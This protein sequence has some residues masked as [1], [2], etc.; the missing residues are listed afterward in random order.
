V[1]VV[2]DAPVA[3]HGGASW[4]DAGS[5]ELVRGTVHFGLDPRAVAN[6][7][8]V[9]LD[10]AAV[11]EDGLVPFDAD[12][13]ILRPAGGA[14]ARRLLFVVANRG[15]LGGVP[16]GSRPA[17]WGSS[18][19]DPGDGLVLRRG[20]TVAWCG[21]QWDVLRQRGG[22]GLSAPQA[23]DGGAP[24]AGQLRV[25][26]HSAV[27]LADHALSDSSPLFAFADYPTA[28][29]DDPT[30]VLT[31]RDWQEGPRQ[32]I[33]RARW[34]FAHD[35]EGT[36]VA[37]DT[38]VWLEGGFEP[39][40]FYE[41][42]YRT[43]ICPIA[44]TG[45][46]AMRDFVSFLRHGASGD[47][48]PCAD[49]IDHAV[50]FGVSQSARALRQL[51]YEGMNVD[52]A[53]RRVF[54]GV[55]AHI[56][57]GRRG[58]FNHRYAQPS[59]T[60]TA[61]FGFLPPF[62]TDRADGGGLYARQRRIGGVPRTMFT[63]SSWEY[64]RGGAGL[65]HIDSDIDSD[66]DLTDPDD[67]RSY[68]FAGMDHV[69]DS[70]ELKA[71]LPLANRPNPI[72]PALLLRAAFVNIERWVCDDVAPPPSAV[73][74]L[75]DATAVSRQDVLAAFP[76]VPG[77]GF[78]DP[79]VLPSINHIDLGPDAERGI[80]R[81]PIVEGDPYPMY[82]SSID[83]DGNEVAGVRVPELAVPLGTSTAW[84]P[85]T[86]VDGLPDVIFEFAGSWFPFA[87]AVDERD[88]TG[89]RRPSI[90]ERYD[91]RDDYLARVRAAA[92]QLVTERFLLAEDVDLA[93]ERA[94]RLYDQ[95]VATAT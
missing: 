75:S 57:G 72:G 32:T 14:G 49:T 20:W 22:L 69:G 85:R 31:V 24:I 59:V 89:D 35:D 77:A 21:W 41:L 47:G 81:W 45:L 11:D 10:K 93:V 26:I 34:R 56:G 25:E 18:E 9:D 91:G 12:M 52:E 4:G 37:D 79:K 44:G 84:N 28:D 48:N 68:L 1:R 70:V 55:L 29:V 88:G 15:N 58:E 90:V 80:G 43:R 30:A 67:V 74:R 8:I 51:V 65:T 78:P 50:G 73:P 5:Y 38:H 42:V 62:A 7:P 94:A 60:A 40:R 82:V 16:L 3:F 46:A 17:A 27:R 71:R 53:G 64:W 2:S 23:L 92:E 61:G 87:A 63:N 39:Y 76:S 13:C 36:P 19:I 95:V 86:P 83:A 6:A 33:Q 54:D 66:T